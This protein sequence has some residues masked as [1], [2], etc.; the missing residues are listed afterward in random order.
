MNVTIIRS[1]WAWT[2]PTL[3]EDTSVLQNSVGFMEDQKSIMTKHETE[4][5]RR[6]QCEVTYLLILVSKRM[7]KYFNI[8]LYP[9]PNNNHPSWYRI[10]WHIPYAKT[11]HLRIK[12]ADVEGNL[13]QWS[14]YYLIVK[15]PSGYSFSPKGT[16]HCEILQQHEIIQS[17]IYSKNVWCQMYSNILWNKRKYL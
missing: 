13:P 17:I 16:P 10:L 5:Q 3:S 2:V 9:L 11:I 4:V 14:R 6:L 7:H 8:R 12:C 1:I 15:G